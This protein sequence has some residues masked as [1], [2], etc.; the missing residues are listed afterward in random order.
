MKKILGSLLLLSL[1]LFA[2]STYEWKVELKDR[3]LYLHQATVLSMECSFSKEGKND[4]VKFIPPRDVPFEFKLLNE[5]RHFE[6]DIQTLKYRYL[7]FANKAGSYDLI[8]KPKMLFTTQSAI[9]NVIVGRDNVNDLEMEKETAKIEPI[10]V[11]VDETSS[12]LTG[13]FVL[14]SQLDKTKSAA[15]EPVHLEIEIEGEGN[16][17]ALEPINF[18][19]EGVQ[20]FSDE[21]EKT[22]VL[23]EQG[24]KGKWLQRFAFVGTQDFVIPSVT[25]VYFDLQGKKELSLKTP[26]YRLEIDDAG[27]KRED[28]IDKVDLPIQKIQ[29]KA[30]V[31]YV[32]YALT[33]LAGFIFA[34]LFRLP[35][36]SVKQEKGINIK[37]AKTAK[38]L[39]DVL[40]LCEKNLFSHEIEVLEEAVYKGG[41]VELSALKKSA[42][43]RL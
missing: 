43:L 18:E 11:V 7:V 32:Y 12:S 13:K 9:D 31:G 16:M 30:Y 4:D 40:I 37:K 3:Q 25:V 1:S 2:K 29:W 23:G 26:V 14:H 28:L 5:K 42:L 10:P 36:R 22:F 27:M 38:E 34:K 33:F 6:G 24:Y 39:L 15:F 17:Q 35:Q 41:K 21:P 8:L 20:V 19:I